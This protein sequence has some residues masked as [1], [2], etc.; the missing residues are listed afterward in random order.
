MFF[1]LETERRP[2]FFQSADLLFGLIEVFLGLLQFGQ[3][4]VFFPLKLFDLGLQR[5][6]LLQA[7]HGRGVQINA[8]GKLLKSTEV[9]SVPPLKVDVE[10][11]SYLLHSTENES[12]RRPVAV[13]I[14]ENVVPKAQYAEHRLA[15]G[16]RI[17]IATFVGGGSEPA[18]PADK[19]LVIGKFRFMS[20][21]ITGTGKYASYDLMRDCLAAS[22]C[23]VTT[24]AVRR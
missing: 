21:L 6:A 2:L 23:E 15:A 16:D 3:Q 22:A 11:L 24:V 4:F 12:E 9:R 5:L 10:L 20:R 7:P 19:P 1:Q 14:N 17:E 8:F 13:E 18:V